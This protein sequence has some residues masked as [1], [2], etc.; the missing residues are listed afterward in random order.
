MRLQLIS[1]NSSLARQYLIG[2]VLKFVRSCTAY[3][4]D[5]QLGSPLKSICSICQ[6][7]A[8]LA[9]G[10]GFNGCTGSRRFQW[11]A[12]A[13]LEREFLQS[14]RSATKQ[15]KKIY[16][17]AGKVTPQQHQFDHMEFSIAVLSMVTERSIHGPPAC[18]VLF[19]GKVKRLQVCTDE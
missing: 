6:L 3:R 13:Q 1:S 17:K 16:K 4:S 19:A 15:S 7:D 9:A 11:L 18:T 14:C 5:R 8:S 2:R 10:R 12:L